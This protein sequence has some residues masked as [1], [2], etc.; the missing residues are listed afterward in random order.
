MEAGWAL[1]PVWTLIY[2]YCFIKSEKM[3][4]RVQILALM[5]PTLR[6]AVGFLSP[7]RQMLGLYFIEYPVTLYLALYNLYSWYSVIKESKK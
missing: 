1:E 6:S 4:F 5:L 7:S 3:I 2:K